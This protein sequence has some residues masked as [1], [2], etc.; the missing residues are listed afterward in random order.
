MKLEIELP[1]DTVIPLLSMYPKRGKTSVH[2]RYINPSMFFHIL[3]TKSH[4]SQDAELA[5][6]S[7]KG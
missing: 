1:Y 4:N 5:L 7:I 2:G 6:V 3:S